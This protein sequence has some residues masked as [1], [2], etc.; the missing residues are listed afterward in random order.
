MI[1]S[2]LDS[3]PWNPYASSRISKASLCL[4]FPL[5][6]G[7]IRCIA[8][9]Q[10]SFAFLS[11]SHCGAVLFRGIAFHSQCHLAIPV[12]GF[13]IPFPGGASHINSVSLQSMATQIRFGAGQRKATSFRG[14][15]SLFQ[16]RAFSNRCI[17]SAMRV[18]S[19]PVLC[20]SFP[21]R[22]QFNRS[23][24]VSVR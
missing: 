5:W 9:P 6:R 13:S 20:F 16:H 22:V 4:S 17:S 7:S 11:R 15:A 21:L 19:V 8:Y 23:A 3:H 24:S 14:Q 12:Q 10:P 18:R 1:P 2:Q